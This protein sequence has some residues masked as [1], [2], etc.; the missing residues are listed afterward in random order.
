M[1]RDLVD[2]ARLDLTEPIA[3][4]ALLVP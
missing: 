3:P 2:F 4:L 1:S